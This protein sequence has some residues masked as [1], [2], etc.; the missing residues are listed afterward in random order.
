MNVHLGR[1]I[2]LLQEGLSVITIGKSKRPNFI[3]KHCQTEPQSV[4]KLTEYGEYTGGKFKKDGNEIEGTTGFGIVCGYKGLECV[5]VDLKVI[6]NLLDQKDFWA[7]FLQLLKDH[8][9]DF[10]QKFVI[11]KTINSGY[12]I[13]YRCE[14]IEGNLKLAV[15]KGQKEAIIETRGIGGYIFIYD[16]QISDFGYEAIKEISQE[17]RDVL[18]GLC[19]YFNYEEKQAEEIKDKSFESALTPWQDYNQR[20]DVFD[21]FESDFQIV[22]QIDRKSV[23]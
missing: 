15:L 12:H 19:R 21:A 18:I 9:D 2:N 13:L 10:D 20:H 5:D 22:R 4:E 17:D 14:K 7:S 6:P 11:Y 8:I 1:A 23:V 16:N 3:W